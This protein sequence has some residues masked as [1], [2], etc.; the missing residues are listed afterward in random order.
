MLPPYQHKGY[1]SLLVEVLSNV[2]VSE[3][4]YDCTIEEPLEYFQH[5]R[6]CVDIKRLLHFA[7]VQE[8]VNSA[9][10]LLKQG[11]LSKKSHVP[12]FTPPSRVVENVRKTLKINRKQ[13]LQ[14]WDILIY[15]GLDPVDKYMEDFVTIISNRVKGDILGKDSGSGGSGK[16]VIEV[17]S[18]YNPEMSFVMFRSQ[19]GEAPCVQM[20]ENQT[21]QEEQLR[22]LVD[23]RVKEIK[24]IAQKMHH[25]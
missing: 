8:A 15:L 12:R 23:E 11:K 6:T 18:D 2:A 24:L 19:G 4:V 14:C 22:Q 7:P 16:Q 13:F 5:V 25:A 9:V 17:P 20:D 21:N 1:A 3:D 10:S